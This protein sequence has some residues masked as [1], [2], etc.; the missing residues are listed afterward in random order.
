MLLEPVPEFLGR[1]GGGWVPFE[2]AWV[3]VPEVGDEDA[4][5]VVAGEDVGTL[6]GLG[7]VPEDIGNDEDADSGGGGPG[8]VCGG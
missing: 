1:S 6:K 4:E 8:D 3:V 7:V 2:W 5:G